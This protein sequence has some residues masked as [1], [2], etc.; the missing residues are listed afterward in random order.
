MSGWQQIETAPKDGTMILILLKRMGDLIVRAR[1]NTVHKHWLT[2]YEGE[3]GITRPY[4]YHPGDLWHH[5]PE[6]P[7]ET[8]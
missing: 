4:F 5:M 2:D 7:K 1:F 8:S 3:G 6:L